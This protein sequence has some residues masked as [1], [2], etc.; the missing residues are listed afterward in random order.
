M[1]YIFDGTYQ[2]FLCCVFT[3]FEYKDTAVRLQ[4]SGDDACQT[5][6]FSASRSI[7]TD[8]PKAQRVQHGLQKHVGSTVAMDFFSV[9]L[10]E[11]RKAWAAAFYIVCRIFSGQADILENFGDD[12]VLYFTQTVKKVSRERH[13]MKAFVRFQKSN[14]G[15]FFAVIEPDFNVLPLIADFFKKRYADQKWL[16]YDVKRKYGLLYDKRT[17]SEVN[18]SPEDKQ[19]LSADEVITLDEKD[20]HFQ[21]LWKRYFQSTNIEARRNMKLHLQHVPRRY[22]KYL[23]E[24]Q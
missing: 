11:D 3:Y 9:L 17:V 22:W 14:D 6:M 23:V 20:E 19:A 10:S 7:V 1:I 15:L 12:Q 24:K 16:I 5:D 18:I 13:R 21:Q 4:L 2:G 8:V